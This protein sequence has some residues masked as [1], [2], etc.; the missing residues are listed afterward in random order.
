SSQ[1]GRATKQPERIMRDPWRTVNGAPCRLALAKQTSVG[2]HDRAL[3]PVQQATTHF[4]AVDGLPFPLGALSRRGKGPSEGCSLAAPS[5]LVM[6]RGQWGEA[7]ASA[8]RAFPNECGAQV[9]V[10]KHGR[11]CDRT[12]IAWS[13]LE[14]EAAPLRL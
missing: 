3:L 9:G 4:T 8:Q 6:E 12:R 1:V 10:R 13:V 11:A 7:R 2:A 5:P 14:V